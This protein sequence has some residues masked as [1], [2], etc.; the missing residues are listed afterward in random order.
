M[1]NIKAA[2]P[3]LRGCPRADIVLLLGGVRLEEQAWSTS[4]LNLASA[5]EKVRIVVE[6]GA[7]LGSK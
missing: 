1:D 7:P 5:T 4:V 2:I 6:A 3:A